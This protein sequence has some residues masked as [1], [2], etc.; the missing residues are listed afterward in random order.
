[1]KT[2]TALVA[3]LTLIYPLSAQSSA[4]SDVVVTAERTEDKSVC[5]WNTFIETAQEVQKLRETRRLSATRFAEMMDDPNT[6][7]LDA[8]GERDFDR[9][10]VK[11][12][13]NLPFT[14]FSRTKL[15]QIIPNASRTRILIYCRNNLVQPKDGTLFLEFAKDQP[16]GLN[17]PV[18]ITLYLYGY[19]DVWELD[20][21]VDPNDSPIPFVRAGE[22]DAPKKPPLEFR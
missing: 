10:H 17:I 16:A 7:V 13:I 5:D 15:R 6:I 9:L 11:A 14:S 21:A 12:S 4:Q 2:V 18:F 1:M 8:R 20:P 19:K 3:S 22:S